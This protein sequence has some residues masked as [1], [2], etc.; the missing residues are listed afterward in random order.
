MAEINSKPLPCTAL[1]NARQAAAYLG[2]SVQWLAVL[3]MQGR[4]PAYHKAGSWVRYRVSDL[5]AW[6]AQHR[7]A[8]ATESA[9]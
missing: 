3:R 6:V 5:D 9:A 8:T 1:I 7:V 4:G 2:C